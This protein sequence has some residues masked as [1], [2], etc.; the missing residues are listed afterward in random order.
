MCGAR[1]N[2][3]HGT[4]VL[5]RKAKDDYQISRIVHSLGLTSY[6]DMRAH[7]HLCGFSGCCAFVEELLCASAAWLHLVAAGIQ[8]VPTSDNSTQ[9]ATQVL[10]KVVLCASAQ[11]Q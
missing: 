7:G 3:G 8:P 10:L 6:F 4:Q 2:D 11:V 1:H 9:L 5:S